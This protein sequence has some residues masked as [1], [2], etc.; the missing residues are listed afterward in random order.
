MLQLVVLKSMPF[1]PG[2]CRGIIVLCGLLF[3][4]SAGGC[5]RGPKW[6]LAR[7]EGTVT[8]G[9]SPLRGIQ[10]VFLADVDAGTQGPRASG[11][12][13]EAGHYRLRTDIGEEGVVA[14]KHRV[15]L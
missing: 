5:Q 9:D 8:K 1:V 3:L 11:F 10:V 14:G 7:V 12:T 2:T 13:D 6:N 15:M 4:T